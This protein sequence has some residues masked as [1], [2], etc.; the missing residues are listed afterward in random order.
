MFETTNQMRTSSPIMRFSK[1]ITSNNGYAEHRQGALVQ[2]SRHARVHGI[3]HGTKVQVIEPSAAK[4][5]VENDMA[6]SFP[7]RMVAGCI[8]RLSNVQKQSCLLMFVQDLIDAKSRAVV[9]SEVTSATTRMT[10]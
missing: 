4:R 3:H 5:Q 6:M 10:F 9:K 7:G 8:P 1:S 2:S